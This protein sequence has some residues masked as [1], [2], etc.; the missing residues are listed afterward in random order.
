MREHHRTCRRGALI[1][2]VQ[3]AAEYGTKPHDLEKRAVDD[4]RLHQARLL[5][6]TDQREVDGGKITECRDCR[7]ARLEVID[8]RNREGEVVGPDAR[9]CLADVDQPV[10]VPIDEG[11]EEYALYD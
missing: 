10:C 7:G 3:Q 2:G 9:R 1:G 5:A 11:T 8:F 6:E 4:T